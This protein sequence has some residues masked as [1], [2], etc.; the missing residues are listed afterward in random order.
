MRL[1]GLVECTQSKRINKILNVRPFRYFFGF[2]RRCVYCLALPPFELFQFCGHYMHAL[3]LAHQIE[4]NHRLH[5]QE[6][7]ERRCY[8]SSQC[9]GI[10][11]LPVRTYSRTPL[12]RTI[13]F[14]SHDRNVPKV[15]EHVYKWLEGH[16]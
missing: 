4:S 13:D 6:F 8:A 3:H 2:V 10:L 15:K 14:I 9:V 16:V 11:P 1:C 5:V 12:S 7:N